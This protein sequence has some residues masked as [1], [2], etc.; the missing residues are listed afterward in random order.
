MTR[1]RWWLRIVG[2]LYV[3]DFVMKTFVKAPI[4]SV[5]RADVL[6][7]AAAG[8]PAAR[9][10]V[11]TWVGF[12]LE[13]GAVGLVLLIASRTPEIARPLVWVVIA[14][15]LLRGL[16]FDSYMLARGY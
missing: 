11:D 2:A 10:A 5:G 16:A 14:I 7:L 15:E 12:G 6:D 4:R 13:T 9:L 3:V 8:D 1:L